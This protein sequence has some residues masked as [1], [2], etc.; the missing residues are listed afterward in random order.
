MPLSADVVGCSV[1]TEAEVDARWTMAYAAAVGATTSPYLDTTRPGGVAVHPVFPVALEWPGLTAMRARPEMRSLSRD[2]AARGVHTSHD[3]TWHR[4]LGPGRVVTRATVVGVER[5]SAGTAYTTR[6]ETFDRT[7]APVV[8]SVMTSV[9]LGVELDGPGHPAGPSAPRL[10]TGWLPDVTR[11][12]AVSAGAAHVYSECARIWNPIHTDPTVA[13]AAGLPAII[14]HGT[15]TLAMGVGAV[16]EELGGGD[17]RRVARLAGR[18]RAMVTMPTTLQV[19][20]GVRDADG[21][22]GFRVRTAEGSVAV[23]DGLV[24]LAPTSR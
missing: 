16:V 22:I 21:T 19:E 12:V 17:P 9:F 24:T 15:A 8:T 7:G 3:T 6:H 5:R 4:P 18:F 20:I 1:E 13:A 2:E 14:L 10:P 11:S 23:D